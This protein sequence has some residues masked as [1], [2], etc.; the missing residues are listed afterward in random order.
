MC[1]QRTDG[2][3]L[4]EF[5]RRGHNSVG[6]EKLSALFAG[7]DEGCRAVV[8]R[9]QSAQFHITLSAAYY[10]QFGM[11]IFRVL[12]RIP[13][14]ILHIR[15]IPF[16]VQ[17]Y[18]RIDES[19]VF[20]IHV[21]EDNRSVR[22]VGHFHAR[23][24]TLVV[25][26]RRAVQRAVQVRI[27]RQIVGQILQSDDL[28]CRR[29]VRIFVPDADFADLQFALMFTDINVHAGCRIAEIQCRGADDR[30][31]VRFKWR[32][33]RCIAVN[34]SAGLPLIVDAVFSHILCI[35]FKGSALVDKSV[36]DVNLCCGICPDIAGSVRFAD[37][38]QLCSGIAVNVAAADI[39]RL[40][41]SGDFCSIMTYNGKVICPD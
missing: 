30:I 8:K 38:V 7:P 41:G 20:K 4:R 22:A 37:C 26:D 1:P 18:T 23:D 16:A 33:A 17:E 32:V 39:F 11:Y 27:S 6:A 34:E 21:F 29:G 24:H 36:S 19:F 25:N 5:H 15:H 28:L 13:G 2:V 31:S 10:F 35:N 3:V 9:D 40:C 12:F 14:R